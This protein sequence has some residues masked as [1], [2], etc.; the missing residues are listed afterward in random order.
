MGAVET[1]MMDSISLFNIDTGDAV[2]YF[3]TW[4]EGEETL[5]RIADADP[6]GVACLALVAYDKTGDLVAHLP[7]ANLHPSATA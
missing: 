6:E 4:E 2:R 3:H 1:Y 5:G 7:G